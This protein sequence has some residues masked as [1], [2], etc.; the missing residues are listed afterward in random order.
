MMNEINENLNAIEL[1]DSELEE[2]TGGKKKYNIEGDSGKSNVRT[3]PGLDYKSIG[4]LHKGEEAKFLGETSV[5]DRGVLWYKISWNGRKAW[6]S[7]R[8][9]V[10]VRYA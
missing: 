5:D 9:T 10:K 1:N 4:V 6:V 2:V 7:S 3:G 8:Y